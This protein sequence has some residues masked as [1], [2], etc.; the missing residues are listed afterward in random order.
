MDSKPTIAS[1]IRSVETALAELE[2]ELESADS[3]HKETLQKQIAKL[4]QALRRLGRHT[5]H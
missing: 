1:R 2:R 3:A 4:H 5:L